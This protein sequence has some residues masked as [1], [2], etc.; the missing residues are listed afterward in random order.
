M[1][2]LLLCEPNISEGRDLAL[3]EQVAD[4][5]RSVAGVKLMDASMETALIE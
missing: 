2:K 1:R 3:V 5:V 4:E